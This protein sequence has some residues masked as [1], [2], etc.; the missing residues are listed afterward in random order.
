[1]NLDYVESFHLHAWRYQN[2]AMIRLLPRKLT[3]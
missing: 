2:A 1:M 3:F